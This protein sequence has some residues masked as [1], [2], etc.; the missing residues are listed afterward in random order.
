MVVPVCDS[1]SAGDESLDS[2]LHRCVA[3]TLPHP[4]RSANDSSESADQRLCAPLY[5]APSA[6]L[7]FF[8]DWAT[9]GTIIRAVHITELRN[10]LDRALS[11]L[12]FATSAQLTGRSRRQGSAF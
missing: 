4:A 2:S 8:T 7:T 11:A 1:K 3:A 10:V 6:G 12:G 5:R 9:P